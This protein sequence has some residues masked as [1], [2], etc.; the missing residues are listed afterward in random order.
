MVKPTTGIEAASPPSKL[1]S[2]LGPGGGVPPVR[3][4]EIPFQDIKYPAVDHTVTPTA[5]GLGRVA[6]S[7]ASI[8][9][10]WMKL[11]VCFVIA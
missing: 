3:A 6:P 4:Q 8:T 10:G 5:P 7:I 1:E 11:R 2:P 9:T